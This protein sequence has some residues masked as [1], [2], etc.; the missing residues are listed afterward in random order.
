LELPANGWI[1]RYRAR[2]FGRLTQEDLDGL[3]RGIVIDG[4]KYQPVEAKLDRQQG[5]NAWATIA[6]KEGKNRE[7]RR[8]MEHIGVQVN[9]LIRVSFGPF[10]LGQVKEGAVEEIPSRTMRELLGIKKGVGW[11]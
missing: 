1:R 3:L 4:I 2:V 7:V 6:L 5:G 8:L 10:N 9:R 11:A